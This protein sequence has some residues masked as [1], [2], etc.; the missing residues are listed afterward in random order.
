MDE[1]EGTF[2]AIAAGSPDE[3][4]NSLLVAVEDNTEVHR[5]VLPYR[6]WELLDV[7]GQGAG[8]HD[9]PPVGPLLRQERA[10][11]AATPPRPTSPGPSCRGCSTSTTCRGR[12]PARS[13]PATSGSRRCARRSSS[14]ARPT[15]ADAV[16]AALAEG[17]DPADDRRGDRA[18]RESAR[19]PRRRPPR[20]LGL[21]GQAA[22]ERPRRLGRRPRERRGQRL[23]EHGAR[24]QPAERGRLPDPRRLRGRP[25]PPGPRRRVPQVGP[26]PA[27]RGPRRGQDDRPEGACWPRPNPR[28]GRTSRRSPP[29]WCTATARSATTPRRCSR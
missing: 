12:P 24:G 4:F 17:I 21:A 29:R 19:P 2:A 16:A 25:R 14:R 13:G 9:A 8:P 10:R 22:G 26:A 27:R 11:P 18:G 20:A 15:A 3:A 28:S 7:V 1:A 23:A 5:V 6:A